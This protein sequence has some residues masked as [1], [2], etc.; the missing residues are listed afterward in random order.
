MGRR[1]QKMKKLR[2]MINLLLTCLAL[3]E[4][5]QIT[6]TQILPKVKAFGGGGKGAAGFF[7]QKQTYLTRDE[8]FLVRRDKF[9]KDV[10]GL[11]NVTSL[12]NGSN[13]AMLNNDGYEPWELLG[14]R[15][16]KG[17]LV[18]LEN[19]SKRILDHAQIYN[20]CGYKDTEYGQEQNIGTSVR[21]VFLLHNYDKSLTSSCGSLSWQIMDKAGIPHRVPGGNGLRLYVSWSSLDAVSGNKCKKGKRNEFVVGFEEI[22]LDSMGHEVNEWKEK[23]VYK[24]VHTPEIIKESNF[25]TDQNTLSS[26]VESPDGELEVLVEMGPDCLSKLKVQVLGRHKSAIDVL[27]ADSDVYTSDEIWEQMIR[28]AWLDIVKTINRDKALYGV[29]LVPMYVDSLMNEAI[30]IK[31]EIVGYQVDLSMWN[32]TVHGIE[33]IHLAKLVL[34]RGQGLNN[35]RE[36]ATIDLGNITVKGMYQYTAKCTAWICVIDSFD[37]EGPQPFE[38]TMS[39]AKVKVEVKIQTLDQCGKKNNLI[40]TDLNLPLE[41]QEVKFDFTNIGSVL[42]TGVAIIGDLALGVVQGMVVDF[43]KE[44][45]RKELPTILCEDLPR[46]I[47]RVD[48]VT[49]K[50]DQEKEPEWYGILKNGTGGWG[51]DNLR[52]DFLAEQ[53]VKKVFKDGV[54]KHFKNDSDPLV[55]A[56]DPFQLLSASE[57]IHERGLIKGHIVA[58][59]LFLYGLR[60]LNLTDMK[61]VRNEDLTFSALRVTIELPEANLTGKFRLS[62]LKLLSVISAKE[63]EGTIHAHLTGIKVV[64][65]VA[66]NTNKVTNESADALIKINHF[67]VDFAKERANIDVQGLGGKIMGKITNKGIKKIGN[68]LIDMQKE[69]LN[70]EIKNIMWGLAKCLMYQPGQ[71]F[72]TCMDNFWACLG[73]EIPFKFP[74]CPSMYKE[75]DAEIANFSSYRTYL[76]D[77]KKKKA[78]KELNVAQRECLR[79]P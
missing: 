56:L 71:G 62:H 57:D 61:L 48:R 17:V 46:N 51:W 10:E 65:T 12:K 19:H 39:G 26:W 31:E 42:G 68:K 53:F 22:E 16:T 67:E 60:N 77:Y 58:C 24:K 29:G 3:A 49:P 40:I 27:E 7:D 30:V 21:D 64:L 59:E 28:Q 33:D 35:L 72:N 8:K 15:A 52:R 73:F 44:G 79:K 5:D 43:A 45:V 13:L 11:L 14:K 4:V 70:M 2:L 75:A 20:R 25:L 55:K 69:M 37:S 47:S 18:S 50:V 6:G 78:E 54:V 34:E 32:I 41:Y 1:Q 74:T 63:R 9:E 38:I 36:E 23:K 76:K 66:M